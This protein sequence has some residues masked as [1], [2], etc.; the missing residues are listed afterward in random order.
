MSFKS[1]GFPLSRESR[2]GTFRRSCYEGCYEIHDNPTVKLRDAQLADGIDYRCS[3]CGQPISGKVVSPRQIRI[4]VFQLYIFVPVSQLAV[5]TRVA[6]FILLTLLDRAL[7]S[8]LILRFLDGYNLNPL[9]YTTSRFFMCHGT[10]DKRAFAMSTNEGRR[11]S[12]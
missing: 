11:F 12:A 1:S 8:V 4:S 5:H 6:A 7:A 3:A 2:N 10:P 9:G